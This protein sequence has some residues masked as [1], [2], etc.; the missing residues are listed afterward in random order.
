MDIRPILD[1]AISIRDFK[2]F[3]WLKEELVE[4]CR[5]EGLKTAGSKRDISARIE[6]YLISGERSLGAKERKYSSSSKFDWQKEILSSQTLITDNY[7]NTENVR[8]YFKEEIGCHFKFNVKFMNWMKANVGRN[9]GDAAE[10]WRR[11]QWESKAL[12]IGNLEA[13]IN[14]ESK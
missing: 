2:E 14:V 10:E 4:F 12:W 1:T 7:R 8:Q 13:K 5:K 3:Y 6:R 11:I 9:L